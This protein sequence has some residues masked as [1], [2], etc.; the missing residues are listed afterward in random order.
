MPSLVRRKLIVFL[1]TDIITSA[2]ENFPN[3]DENRQFIH[4]DL[5]DNIIIS[6]SKKRIYIE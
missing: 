4:W 3:I 6:F 1:C 5:N 2:L